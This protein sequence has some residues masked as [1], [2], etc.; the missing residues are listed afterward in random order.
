MSNRME[1]K[2]RRDKS[3][4]INAQPRDNIEREREEKKNQHKGYAEKPKNWNFI[5]YSNWGPASAVSSSFGLFYLSF[6]KTH[7]KYS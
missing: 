1:L 5:P 6:S 3:T 2:S 4:S 7:I